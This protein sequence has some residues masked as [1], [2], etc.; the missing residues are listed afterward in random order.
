MRAR[1]RMGLLNRTLTYSKDHRLQLVRITLNRIATHALNMA[2]TENHIPNL[3]YGH[4]PTESR[5]ALAR[6]PETQRVNFTPRENV[7]QVR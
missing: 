7:A 4:G 5:G 3:K 1:V 6:V 2:I